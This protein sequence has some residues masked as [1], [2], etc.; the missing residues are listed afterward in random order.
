M[1]CDRRPLGERRT[2]SLGLSVATAGAIASSLAS[3]VWILVLSLFVA[4]V[5]CASVMVASGR[6]VA[7]WFPPQQRGVAMGI[8]QSAPPVGIAA[9]AAVVPNL[10]DSIGIGGALIFAAVALGAALVL[11]MVVVR[12]PTV[13]V[14]DDD[15][16]RVR[17]S[18]YRDPR[19]RLLRVHLT[20]ALL[21]VPQVTIWTFL[22]VWLVAVHHWSVAAAS[23]A[24]AAVQL[25]GAAGR[26]L[27]GRWSDVRGTRM[28]PLRLIA[29][30]AAV[31]MGVLAVSGESPVSIVLIFV[32]SIVVVADN[33]IAFTAVAELAGPWWSGRAMGAQNTGQN[34][35]GAAVPPVGGALIA[36]GG[37]SLA[38]AV[39]GVIALLAVP[40]VP[41]RGEQDPRV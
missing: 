23:I 8:R 31:A 37:Y 27:A 2:L 6:L 26:I 15:S 12:E 13:L 39:A 3:D 40:L 14:S 29:F 30:A 36:T 5:G 38:F 17:R 1:G 10:A 24:V 22:L 4:G 28:R 20:A 19:H 25:A 9:A 35:V 41:T 34:A 11:A 21:I 16:E 18:P 33:G 7:G 32:A